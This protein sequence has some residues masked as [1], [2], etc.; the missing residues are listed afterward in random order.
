M[1]TYVVGDVQGC[2]LSLM[3][4]MDTIGFDPDE[5]RVW[6]AGDLVNRGP[7]SLAVLQ[8]AVEHQ[9]AVDSVLGN[10]DLHLLR[11]RMGLRKPSDS[12]T[13]QELLEAPDADH[14]LDWLQKRP[15]L[16]LENGWAVVH[17][18]VRPGWSLTGAESRARDLSLALLEDPEEVLAPEGSHRSLLEVLTLMRTCD[19]DGA[20][21][22]SFKGPPQKAPDH[23]KPWYAMTDLETLG[24][25][26]VFG[27]WA[28]HGFMRR[29]HAVCLDTGCVWGGEL[30]ALRLEDGEVF[31][32]PCLD[33]GE[34]G[35]S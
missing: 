13:L 4:L 16:I 22:L 27:H 2:F 31:S 19:P 12:D 26:V 14:L 20:P 35:E 23:L 5:D 25:T 7:R 30:T 32:Q 10:H 3:A 8:W 18:G 21:N 29:A 11:L 28:A 9:Q 15:F 17:A 24:G 1:S 34:T 6:F 33:Y